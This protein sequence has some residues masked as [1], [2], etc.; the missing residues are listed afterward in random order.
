MAVIALMRIHCAAA[1]VFVRMSRA[2]AIFGARPATRA[3]LILAQTLRLL[4]R[5]HSLRVDI[6]DEVLVVGLVVRGDSCAVPVSCLLVV[7]GAQS[8]ELVNV[9][10]DADASSFVLL[11][12]LGG[13]VLVLFG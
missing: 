8:V 7:T 4:T 6:D 3:V 9:D 12:L 1:A 5:V 11:V 13:F 2:S 10:V